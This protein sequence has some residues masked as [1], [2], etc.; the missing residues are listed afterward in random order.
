MLMYASVLVE[1]GGGRYKAEKGEIVHID[2]GQGRVT[3]TK[4]KAMW[5]AL[6]VDVQ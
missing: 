2:V 6:E 3:T 4:E 1:G 5:M